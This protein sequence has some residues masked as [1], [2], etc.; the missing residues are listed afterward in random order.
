[1][2]AEA[3]C[4]S[5]AVFAQLEYLMQVMEVKRSRRVSDPVDGA[6]Q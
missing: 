1:V 6:T 3:G 2:L 5:G 4:R